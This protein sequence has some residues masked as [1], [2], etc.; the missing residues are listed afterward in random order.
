MHGKHS[1][2][3]NTANSEYLVINTYQ[4][5]FYGK[6]EMQPNICSPSENGHITVIHDLTVQI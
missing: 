4:L 3:I 1:L 6:I 2:V 5:R